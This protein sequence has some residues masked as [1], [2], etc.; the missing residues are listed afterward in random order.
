M[1]STFLKWSEDGNVMVTSVL[2]YAATMLCRSIVVFGDLTQRE[3]EPATLDETREITAKQVQRVIDMSHMGGGKEEISDE[4]NGMV[5]I[6][7]GDNL[8]LRFRARSYQRGE[9]FPEMEL[10]AGEMQLFV[11]TEQKKRA[12]DRLLDLIHHK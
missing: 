10:P 7:K 1:A 2:D 4:F 6:I 9:D 5:F 8:R 12:Y 11:D 3:F